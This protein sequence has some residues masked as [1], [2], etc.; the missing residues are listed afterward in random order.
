VNA[1]E[2]GVGRPGASFVETV[3]VVDMVDVVDRVDKL[4]G[5]LNLL[6]GKLHSWR[7]FLDNFLEES[8]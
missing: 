5:Q 1:S 8:R 7:D 3:D 4:R 2:N 6:G